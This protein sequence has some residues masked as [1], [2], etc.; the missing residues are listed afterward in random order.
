MIG[1]LFV[2]P[3]SMDSQKKNKWRK[4]WLDIRDSF[5]IQFEKEAS[6][7]INKKNV[8][9]LIFVLFMVILVFLF[10]M[11]NQPSESPDIEDTVP[12]HITE[13]TRKISASE[14]RN[15]AKKQAERFV[16]QYFTYDTR[17]MNRSERI[18]PYVDT[19]LYEE[20]KEADIQIRP[21][22]EM[23]TITFKKMEDVYIQPLN[24]GFL[25]TATLYT[26]VT[27]G[28]GQKSMHRNNVSIVLN[29]EMDQSIWLVSEVILYAEEDS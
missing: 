8:T 6:K 10:N 18:K 12:K 19:A 2:P 25:W 24:D 22:F 20:E 9:L 3:L 23:V 13:P 26:E 4:L 11:N 16:V 1:G 5:L 27:N 7:N 28:K 29:S 17:K 14:A 15:L 21:T